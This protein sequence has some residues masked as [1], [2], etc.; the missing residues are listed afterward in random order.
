MNLDELEWLHRKAVGGDWRN[1]PSN[2]LDE[3][4][5][6]FP[7]L[8]ALARDGERYRW[9]LEDHDDSSTR[10]RCRSILENIAVKTYSAVSRD[11]DAARK[12]EKP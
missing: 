5:K 9:A 2:M 7:A 1:L 10:E 6:A 3:I 8:L 4:W 11:I 12:G